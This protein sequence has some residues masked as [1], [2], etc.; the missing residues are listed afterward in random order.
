MALAQHLENQIS[1]IAYLFPE[2]EKVILFGSRARGDCRET[3]DIDLAVFTSGKLFKNKLLFTE[4]MDRLDTLLKV[5]LVFVSDTTD[6][7]LLKNI[8]KDG[9]VIMEKESKLANYQKAV[10]RLREA[11]SIFQKEPDDL[12]RDGL[13][14]RFEFCC[15]LAWKTCREHLIGL[16]Y[17]EINGPK[18]VMRE[19]FA[20][21]LIDDERIWIEL[22]NDRNRTSHIYD[23]ETAVEIG[24]NIIEKYLEAFEKLLEKL[25]AGGK[26]SN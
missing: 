4:Q 16:G 19:A 7:A 20:N 11:V 2:I 17:E 14:Q 13:I 6:M 15:E 10:S 3:S 8:L 23:E 21:R 18:P 5:D 9:K 12:K 22:L 24:G 26:P 1:Q 25:T